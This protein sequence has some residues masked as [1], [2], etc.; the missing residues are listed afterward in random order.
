MIKKLPD[1]ID[2][3]YLVPGKAEIIHGEI[4][5]MPP[6][7]AL[8]GIAAGRIYISLDAFAGA[9]N[10]GY[11]LPDNVGF[12][13]DLPNRR[14]FSPDA[15]LFVGSVSMQF[16]QGAPLFAVEVRSDHDYGPAAELKIREKRVDYFAAGTAAVWDVDLYG[17]ETIRLY[18]CES[19][20]TPIV[21]RRGEL[22]HAEPVVPGWRM[23]VDNM[24]PKGWTA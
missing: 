16:A 20:D 18:L 11:A 1:C 17:E 6:T 5:S 4:Q 2:G 15:A 19:P 3:L 7:G 21:F 24:Y 14:S 10:F 8:P 22:A 13:V 23:P 12:V 9:N